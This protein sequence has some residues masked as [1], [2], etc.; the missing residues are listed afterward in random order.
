M[1][2]YER[3]IRQRHARR[4][5]ESHSWAFEPDTTGLYPTHKIAT[6]TLALIKHDHIIDNVQRRP[7]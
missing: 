7:L 4:E 3:S 2:P 5:L 6:K 1:T